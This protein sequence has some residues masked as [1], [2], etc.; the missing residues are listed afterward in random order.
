MKLKKNKKS[1]IKKTNSLQFLFEFIVFCIII[2][3][4]K[5]INMD[6]ALWGGNEK[7]FKNIIYV[8]GGSQFSSGI[9]SIFRK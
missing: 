9:I 6:F 3:I 1:K 8:A 7:I 5:I 4:I 2:I